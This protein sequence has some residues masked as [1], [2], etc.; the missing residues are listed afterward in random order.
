MPQAIVW[1]TLVFTLQLA[2][3]HCFSGERTAL[4]PSSETSFLRFV[5]SKPLRVSICNHTRD[6]VLK[7]CGKPVKM[8]WILFLAVHSSI[9]CMRS[10]LS[11]TR[12]H[13]VLCLRVRGK[14]CAGHWWTT[15]GVTCNTDTNTQMTLISAVWSWIVR[16]ASFSRR[17]V[18]TTPFHTACD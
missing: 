4:A 17:A 1:R 6:H 16:H 9:G 13:T 3:W 2:T 18:G 11:E 5:V 12:S 8:T 7:N 14:C 10:T 15:S